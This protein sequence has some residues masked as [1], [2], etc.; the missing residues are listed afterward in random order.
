MLT[1]SYTTEAGYMLIQSEKSL[2]LVI[3]VQERLTPAISDAPRLTANIIRLLQAAKLLQVPC[4]GTEQYPKGLGKTLGDVA[5]LIPSDSMIEKI[6]FS[7]MGEPGFAERLKA[8]GR[9]QIVVVGM[10]AHI[11]VLQTTM[12]LRDAGYEVFAVDDGMGSRVRANTDL[13]IDRM[14]PAG[15]E[16]VSTEMVIFE[17]ARRAN[18][19]C[20][21]QLSALIK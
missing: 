15:V 4:L 5:A 18:R 7:A 10:E 16:V 13:A 6:Y 21:K 11:C 17:W 19:D 12:E 3:D 2:L 14:R 9:S 8:T 1:I 20:F